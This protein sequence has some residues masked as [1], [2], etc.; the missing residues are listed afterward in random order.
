MVDVFLNG[1]LAGQVTDG[2]KLVHKMRKLRRTGKTPFDMT[3][4]YDDF[5]V[6][7]FTDG[8]R[9][10]RP[11]IVVEDGKPKLT[12]QDVKAISE[13]KTTWK[14]L[15]EQGKVEF[16]DAA[17]E[18]NIFIAMSS[19]D[20]KK[21]TTHLEIH[22]LTVLGVPASLVPYANHS[23]GDRVNYGCSKGIK[24]ALGI[25][26]VNYP[27]RFD[28]FSNIAHY[29]QTPI[30]R[31]STTSIVGY[32]SHPGGQNMIV[33]MMNWEGF[34]MEDAIIINRGAI[35]RSLGR[36]TY[37]RPYSASER[38]YPGGQEDRI[39]VPS[40]DV[41]GYRAEV[42]YEHLGSDGV[43][44]VEQF[45]GPEDILIGRTSPPRFVGAVN[46][47]R[48][49]V[50]ERRETSVVVKHGEKGF[51]DMVVLSEDRN[52]HKLVKT[53]V[54]DDRIP[55]LGDK[56][57]SRHGQ[58]GVLGLIVPEEDMPCTSDGIVPDIIT[59]PHGIPSRMTVSQLL[60]F[61]GGKSGAIGGKFVNGDPFSPDP[62][63]GMQQMLNSHGFR[64][65]GKEALYDGITGNKFEADIF[66]GIVYYHKLRHMVANKMHARSRGP[67][68]VLTHQPTE[69]RSKKGGLRM[70]E[71][72]KD[73]LV[74]H[75]TGLLLKERF[76]SDKTVIPVCEKC[77]VTAIFDRARNRTLCPLC[78]EGAVYFIEISYA[79]YV[80]IN[81]MM[82][83]GIY[84]KI[85]LE[86]K[87]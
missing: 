70:G 56:F 25:Y 48:R 37:Y 49:G 38:R 5:A 41:G 60:E 40:K 87:G 72:E 22:P 62:V 81:E 29:P 15:V 46:I 45:I 31:T 14:K 52:G 85:V 18:E 54:R 53:R 84:P 7:I 65:D 32:D 27:M 12:T 33:A 55:E 26:A 69:G 63:K 51:V 73:C 30:V 83:L 78:K 23:R 17:E 8:G 24:Q 64:H 44:E 47:F 2:K 21:D 39:E 50:E 28:T 10:V 13:G 20:I 76:D 34:N 74:A 58:K 6:R 19:D 3:I 11:L 80:L 42:S 43:A 57:S 67:V 4:T 71:M 1:K 61:I 75:G 66:I 35:D 86:D 36:S 68:Q 59:N 9:V 77:G 79:F 82:G 16:L